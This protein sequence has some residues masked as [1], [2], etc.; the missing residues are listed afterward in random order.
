MK[1][2]NRIGLIITGFV[3][4]ASGLAIWSNI[5]TI[6]DHYKNKKAA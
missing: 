6:R 5:I 1:K 4:L 3:V 2:R